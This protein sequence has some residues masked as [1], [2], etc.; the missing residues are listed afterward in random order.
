MEIDQLSKFQ[1]ESMVLMEEE[2][3][4]KMFLTEPIEVFP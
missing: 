2:N 1:D 4:V 3:S